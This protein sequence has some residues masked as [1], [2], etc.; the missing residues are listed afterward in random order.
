M[1][2]D[3][4]AEKRSQR[5]PQGLQ[6]FCIE[7]SSLEVKSVRMEKELHS[8]RTL[9]NKCWVPGTA[10]ILVLITDIDGGFAARV[11]SLPLANQFALFFGYKLDVD[12]RSRQK[13]AGLLLMG[14]I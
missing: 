11:A 1:E 8:I 13:L 5:V 7:G 12:A 4:E 2:L 14:V 3:F 10:S 6:V 9:P